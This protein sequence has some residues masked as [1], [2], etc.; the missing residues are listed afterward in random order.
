MKR[1]GTS[2]KRPE[3]LQSTEHV[4]IVCKHSVLLNEEQRIMP[5]R[6]VCINLANELLRINL[7][8]HYLV[9]RSVLLWAEL[10]SA[11][12][13]AGAAQKLPGAAGGQVGSCCFPPRF[14]LATWFCLKADGLGGNEMAFSN[15]SAEE[16]KTAP[17]EGEEIIFPPFY[18]K[19]VRK[20]GTVTN[21]LISSRT[22]AENA[23]IQNW[24]WNPSVQMWP[25]PEVPRPHQL[26]LLGLGL[27]QAV[28]VTSVCPLVSV[29]ERGWAYLPWWEGAMTF[30]PFVRELQG[31]SNNVQQRCW[32]VNAIQTCIRCLVFCFK[33]PEDGK[34]CSC[35]LADG[36]S[37]IKGPKR[38][39]RCKKLSRG[40]QPCLRE[41]E[42]K[43]LCLWALS[44]EQS[45]RTGFYTLLGLKRWLRW[46]Y[47][48]IKW[49]TWRILWLSLVR[50]YW[51]YVC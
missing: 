9:P 43:D 21:W 41:S 38:S 31:V 11:L 22:R 29:R 6:C 2:L 12:G 18:Q 39:M 24:W 13:A 37:R 4:T 14:N 46:W 50:G 27:S 45:P 7:C 40:I 17:R 23:S 36:C 34:C 10:G 51:T 25:P 35:L 20:V 16:E 33:I 26:L 32:G 1:W 49:S 42:V 28:P 15:H 47:E 19:W 5:K 3:G 30:S 8:Q 48:Q 44:A